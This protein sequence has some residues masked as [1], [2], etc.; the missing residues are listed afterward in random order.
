MEALSAFS[1]RVLSRNILMG[2]G[3]VALT[4]GLAFAGDPPPPDVDITL[5]WNDGSATIGY[6][7]IAD[8][9]QWFYDGDEL[10]MV[11]GDESATWTLD[12]EARTV[13]P[14]VR[15]SSEFVVANIEVF[16]NTASTQTYWVLETKNGISVGPNVNTEG[17]V[18]STLFD[19]GDGSAFM[20]NISSGGHDGA[21]I[22]QA[23]IDGAQHQ[24]LWP[25]GF[26]MNVNSVFGQ[27]SDDDAF[28]DV[29]G[30]GVADS[31][32]V[33]L[34]FEVSA[35]DSVNVIGFFQVDPIPAPATLPALAVLG[36]MGG[37][38]R[39]RA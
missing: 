24:D 4:A 37:R 21:P 38:R 32:S 29:P 15:G 20:R 31:I 39:R 12:W 35:F 22:Y 7:L 25:D 30:P 8:S 14:G 6:D 33:W 2:A 19:L 1:M 26:S 16:N 18:S 17:T 23:L 11:G 9:D 13:R 36:L 10:V 3:V 5:D 34:R 27:D 28:S